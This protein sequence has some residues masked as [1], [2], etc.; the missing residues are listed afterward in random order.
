MQG[1]VVA[2]YIRL[3]MDDGKSDS[4]SIETQRGILDDYIT[5]ELPDAE[6]MEFVDNGYS[7][8]N[9]ERPGFQEMIQLVQSGFINCIVVKDFSRFGRSRIEAGYFIER[10]FPIYTVRFISLSDSFD[11]AEDM[12][13]SSGLEMM[14][15]MVIHEQYSLDLSRKIKAA[16]RTRMMRGERIS[17]YCA[18]GYKKVDNNLEVDE[19]AA[20]SVRQIFSLRAK[21]KSISQIAKHLYDAKTP[22]P[23][24]YKKQVPNPRCMW[25]KSIIQKMLNDEQYI[26]T[27]VAGKTVPVDVGGKQ[28]KV[29]ES[30]WIRIPNHHPAIIDSATFRNVKQKNP[31]ANKQK[32]R[33]GGNYPKSDSP[34][35]G[36]VFCSCCLHKMALSNT[37]NASFHCQH[38]RIASD[39]ECYKSKIVCDT[40]ESLV[41]QQVREIAGNIKCVRRESEGSD[42][43]DK[44]MKIYEQFALGEIDDLT[45]KEKAEQIK[46]GETKKSST[47]NAIEKKI[48]V[49]F[50]K[51]SRNT[52]LSYD[53]VNTLIDRVLVCPNGN[54]EI[55]WSPDVTT[56]CTDYGIK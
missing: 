20:E 22:T 36:K 18:Y 30:D 5:K 44:L 3:S 37:K 49:V 46:Q 32:K 26:G 56:F 13:G 43:T 28:I 53:I 40:L 14:F 54:I 39:A 23:S 17:K 21:G 55:R 24:E 16:N 7:G 11:S 31:P 29:P 25:E 52:E 35:K 2:K 4:L 42:S 33:G 38:T 51:A 19:P 1:Y 48:G 8:T 34:L 15:K 12:N 50:K 6:V 47:T 9:F 41:L 45:Y 27:Y 10:V